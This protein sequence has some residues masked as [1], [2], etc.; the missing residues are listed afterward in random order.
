MAVVLLFEPD[1]LFSSR[2]ESACRKSGLD[3]KVTTT[4]SEF[5]RALKELFPRISLV[6]LDALG[7]GC[8]SLVWL[9][10]GTSKLVGYYSHVDSKLAT[11]ALASGFEIVVP[12]RA[13]A[14]RLGEI[15]SDI[16]SS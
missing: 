14:D 8:K 5:E 7:T 13:F 6:N 16:S 4:M 1:L 3:V 12:R 15:L 10:H 11:E 9:V 2:L